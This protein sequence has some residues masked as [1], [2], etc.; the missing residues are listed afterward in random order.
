MQTKWLPVFENRYENEL[1]VHRTRVRFAKVALVLDCSIGNQG[2]KILAVLISGD[3]Q[4]N[5]VDDGAEI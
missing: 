3:L 4:C 5:L 2:L 1:S